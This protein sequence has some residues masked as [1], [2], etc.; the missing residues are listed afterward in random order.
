MKTLN[1][2]RCWFAVRKR[3]PFGTGAEAFE[4]GH[5]DRARVVPKPMLGPTGLVQLAA[6]PRS[7]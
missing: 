1:C 4:C 5:P 6:C 2:C 7:N 3:Q